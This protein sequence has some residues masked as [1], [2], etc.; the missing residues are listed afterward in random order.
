MAVTKYLDKTG[1]TYFW[2]KIK[3]Y[4]ANML[5][6]SNI[7]G[8]PSSF[9]PA[10]HTHSYLPLSGGTLTGSVNFKNSNI[11]LG[12]P[13]STYQQFVLGHLG[14]DNNSTHCMYFVRDTSGNTTTYIR[15][16]K[17][18]D[19]S[20]YADLTITKRADGSSYASAPT[21]ATSDNSTKIATT[22]FVK[23]QGYL[24]S[25]Q[26]L[27]SLSLTTSGSGNAITALS[28]SNHAITATK[29]STFSLANHTH[30]NLLSAGDNVA[31]TS[32]NTYAS[33][34][35]NVRWFSQTNKVP[36]QP[37]QYGFLATFATGD[38]TSEVH[39][40]WCGQA[41]GD[42]YHRGT[43]GNSYTAP[44][45][46]K[47]IID[48]SNET[49][50][51]VT[52][53]GDGNAVTGIS[54]SNHAIT[55]NKSLTFLTSHQS[56]SNYVTLTGAQTLSGQKTFT[57][58]PITTGRWYC[59]RVDPSLQLNCMEYTKGATLS[60][61]TN[62][63][64]FIHDK[65]ADTVEKTRLGAIRHWIDTSRS[66]CMRIGA[67]RDVANSTEVAILSVTC[68][69]D[70]TK[71]ASCP[72]P[73]DNE[74]STK[75]ATTAWVQKFCSTTKGYLTSHQ[76]LP[77]LSISTSGS[78]N[79]VTS[80][81]VSGHAI[82]VN[83]NTTFLTA[84][85][86]LANYLTKLTNVSEM[87]RHIDM[88]YDNATATYDYDAR[89]YVHAQ[90]NAAGQGEL[91]ILASKV[92]AD[93]FNGALTGNASTATKLATARSISAGNLEFQGSANFDGSGNINLG[94]T[95][96]RSIVSIGNR[97]NYPFHRIAYISTYSGSWNDRGITFLVSKDYHGGGYGIVRI[98]FRT[99][100][101]ASQVAQCSV[102]W[103]VRTSDIS[104]DAI[105]VGFNNTAGASYLDVFYKSPGGYN[106]AVCRVLAC[107]TAR[108]SVGRGFAVI[109][110]STEVN[111]TT[112]S[113]ALDS[114]ES[115]A[116]IA[117]A[118]TK[119]H[120]K[121]YTD[122]IAASD[123]GIVNSAN[124]CSGNAVNVTGTVAIANGGTG[125]TTRL[126]AI[127]ALVNEDVSTNATHFLGLKSDWSKVGY[128]SAANAKTVLGLK[129]AAY[130]ESSAYATSGHTHSYLPL[131]GGTITG[132]INYKV[133]G[134]TRNSSTTGSYPWGIRLI[135]SADKN[136]GGVY[137][138][139]SADKSMQC[140][141][142]CYKSTTTDN[143]WEALR[144]GCDSSG[145][146]YTYAPN[147]AADSNTT[148]IATTKWVRDRGY[149]T[150]H[151][152]LPTL[153]ITT[154]GSGNAITS[155]TVSN[156]AITVN[157]GTTFLTSHQSLSGYV[158][159]NR[160]NETGMNAIYGGADTSNSAALFL[161]GKS[162]SSIPGYFRLYART[163]SSASKLLEGTPS[164]SLKWAGQT[165]QTSSDRRLKTSLTAISDSVLDT[166]EKVDW[167]EFK[168]LEAVSEKGDSA[169]LHIGLIAQDV[170]EVFLQNDL[171]ICDYGILCHDEYDEEDGTHKELWM[172][173]YTEALAMEAAYQRHKNKILENRISELENQLSSVLQT[174]QELKG[175]G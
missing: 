38:N 166:W 125:A 71:Y 69:Y 144:I 120:S 114:V 135:D 24:T 13:P 5:T 95:Y 164:G 27:P 146:F 72:T 124:S 147:P 32:T 73:A 141:L 45:A 110:T 53:S 46:F 30:N 100:D 1:L 84:H 58:S 161:C 160:P 18:N 173:R 34:Y 159:I 111:N 153:S 42:L 47:K 11:T 41:N 2:N 80:V 28:V 90:G 36:G 157:K 145:N 57:S 12:T 44:P 22:A 121:A 104:A 89:I 40:L 4:I 78:G 97:N 88:H 66:S 29:G 91:R 140:C 172:I 9:T 94:V 115:Y 43:N 126:N 174:L 112:V 65:S 35:F 86:S 139:Y 15:A 77:N 56:L 49:Q 154:S 134:I 63:G 76:T 156:H 31:S 33:G 103:L 99:N 118:G 132:Q 37:S 113:D 106:S 62:A 8:K 68:D 163:S 169:R 105:Q 6:W 20:S 151:Q 60:E 51:S 137:F 138:A 162:H 128:I 23:A 142:M 26:T 55:V 75:I 81:T 70:G 130:T 19:A 93:T 123:V 165:V 96:Q 48:S 127:K 67:Y 155:I 158:T 108:N 109:E 149:L 150:S 39:Q 14:N 7:S 92:T 54:V 117:A 129:S 167:G 101:V 148:N 74:N 152:T 133:N 50:L 131:G 21:P 82:T 17:Y 116:T 143:T 59:N 98:I 136:L 61:A 122:I 64:I 171:N 52:T 102:Q 107:S 10:S 16:F 3:T 25:H 175:V 119:L 79:A 87:G 168:F 170:N 83:K 85:Q